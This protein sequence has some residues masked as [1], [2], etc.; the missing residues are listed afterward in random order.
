M[1]I[2]EGEPFEINTASLASSNT[3]YWYWHGYDY[4]T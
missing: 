3:T 1:S 2:V 4:L